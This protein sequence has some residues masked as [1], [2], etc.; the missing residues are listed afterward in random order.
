MTRKSVSLAI[1][2]ALFPESRM[3][4]ESHYRSGVANSDPPPRLSV[5]SL[6]LT[7]WHEPRGKQRTG[8]A[9]PLGSSEPRAAKPGFLSPSLSDLKGHCG[10][11]SPAPA[12]SRPGSAQLLLPHTLP[13]SSPPSWDTATSL[14]HLSPG[15]TFGHLLLRHKGNQNPRSQWQMLP[16]L[17]KYASG[18]GDSPGQP[19]KEEILF[20]IQNKDCVDQCCP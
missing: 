2:K 14:A 15:W 1:N 11:A 12:P 3:P 7:C 13:A 8:G 19:W 18:P 9:P 20:G 6:L 10:L 16:G 4:R 5:W 17:R